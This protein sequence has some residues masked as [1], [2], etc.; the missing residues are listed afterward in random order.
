MWNRHREVRPISPAPIIV[1]ISSVFSNL[2]N[3]TDDATFVTLGDDRFE[4]YDDIDEFGENT[5]LYGSR[6]SSV[7]DRP[8]VMIL[9]LYSSIERHSIN[10]LTDS[11]RITRSRSYSVSSAVC[12]TLCFF[13]LFY[14]TRKIKRYKRKSFLAFRAGFYN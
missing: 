11:T 7:L 8:T 3:G 14:T 9:S 6:F 1:R 5:R 4:R 2:A 12:T 13:F 10:R